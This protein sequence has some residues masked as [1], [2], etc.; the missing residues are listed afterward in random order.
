VHGAAEGAASGTIGRELWTA[1]VVY[2]GVG[3]ALQGGG[4]VVQRRPD[5]SRTVV[6][7]DAR[8]RLTERFP[9]AA[10]VEHR[11][12]LAPPAVNAHTHLD[13]T[14]MPFTA[15]P[16]V[17]FVTAVVAFA[18]TGGRGDAAARRGLAELRVSGTTTIGDIVTSE[19]TMHLLLEAPGLG[20]VAYWEVLESDPERADEVLARTEEA[21]IRFL[22]RQR[23][24]GVRVGLS[25]HAPHT[26]SP[27]LLTGLTALARRLGLP[28]QIH[29][30]ESDGEIELHRRGD[31]PL[32]EVLGPFLASW[33]PSGR[34][35][36]GYLEELGVLAARPT[37]VHMVHVD[38]DDVR[39]V[40]RHGCPVVHCP[41]SNEALEC[42]T[43]PWTLYARHGV[44]VALGTDSRGSSPD[45]DV[46]REWEAAV[47]VHGGAANAAQ[48][49]WAA[50]KGGARALGERPPSVRRG[51]AFDDLLSWRAP[52]H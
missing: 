41:R 8:S 46:R 38:E 15:G 34:T 9:D 29:V 32:R 45:L 42:G 18:R 19:E 4:A 27:A 30:A 14:D 11:T 43:F 28:M 35:P 23:P 47:R 40:A 7:L 25:P 33:R 13:L 12:V 44:S 36:V 48:L 31:G 17:A 51:D 2:G 5:G 26:L 52:V 22:A 10:P 6:A 3:S 1:D 49:V 39:A 20:G 16:Y 21:L 50:V 24:G 37:L